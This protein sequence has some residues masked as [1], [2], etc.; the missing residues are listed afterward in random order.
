M[1]KEVDYNI[2][3]KYLQSTSNDSEWLELLDKFYNYPYTF[4]MTK[5]KAISILYTIYYEIK[6]N[7]IVKNILTDLS[8]S[9]FVEIVQNIQSL[10]ISNNILLDDHIIT[11][12]KYIKKLDNLIKI[13]KNNTNNNTNNNNN[14][15][16]L[17]NLFK[18]NFCI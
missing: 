2:I 17:N 15:N 13:K 18:T 14:I 12:T 4:N 8:Y 11:S 7:S 3:Y 6:F 16:E 10:L 5:E 1:T 9:K